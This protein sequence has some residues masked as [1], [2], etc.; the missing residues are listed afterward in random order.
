M[1]TRRV[2]LSGIGAAGGS[3]AMFQA[4]A[5]LGLNGES[6]YAGPPKLD[7]NVRGTSVVILGAGLAGLVGAL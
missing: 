1:L 6:N 5:S 4:M 7:G 3:M 2:L